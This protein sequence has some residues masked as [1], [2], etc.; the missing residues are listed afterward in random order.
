MRNTF[1]GKRPEFSLPMK[2]LGQITTEK[3]H[4]TLKDIISHA[5]GQFVFRKWQY[6]KLQTLESFL[7]C[8]LMVLDSNNYRNGDISIIYDS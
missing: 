4:P 6:G 3:M 7:F 8:H 2:N 1:M 5:L